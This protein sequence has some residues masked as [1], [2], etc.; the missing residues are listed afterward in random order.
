MRRPK[1]RVARYSS[2]DVR[3]QVESHVTSRINAAFNA[4]SSH[5]ALSKALGGIIKAH[6][7]DVHPAGFSTISFSGVFPA[8]RSILGC[9][10]F[11]TP[12]FHT[13]ADFRGTLAA[14][15]GWIPFPTQGG[16]VG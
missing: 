6:I 14:G 16:E 1:R 10:T 5:S 9:G 8:T 3:Q 12:A 7:D 11:G 4:P 2:A 15:G 13:R